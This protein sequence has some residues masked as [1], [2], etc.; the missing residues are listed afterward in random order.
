MTALL[1]ANGLLFVLTE[2]GG[3]RVIRLLALQATWFGHRLTP[4]FEIWQLLTYG[5]LHGGVG[6]LAF[7]ML[8]LYTLGRVLEYEWGPR[9]FLVYYVA[10]TV[11]AGLTHMAF[12]YAGFR[13][14]PVVG[15]SGAVFGLL[16]AFA[17]RYP[18]TQI[19]LLF[20]PVP[21]RAATAAGL[22]AIASMLLGVTG[23]VPI[24]AHFAHFGGMLGGALMM[25]ALPGLFG[26]PDQ[27]GR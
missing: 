22:Y 2:L 26:R 17:L 24:V 23:Q 3:W 4:S 19:M 12:A 6:H 20:P 8:A 10:C 27:S 1:V 7:N 21:M 9:L 14:G 11:M 13:G 18:N 15:A 25:V 16:L 5:F